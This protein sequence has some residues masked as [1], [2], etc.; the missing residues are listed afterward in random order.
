MLLGGQSRARH[1]P[2]MQASQT[3]GEYGSEVHSFSKVQAG[4]SGPIAHRNQ[5]GWLKG[6]DL[7]KSWRQDRWC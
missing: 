5:S 3:A 4:G 7:Q 1:L 6:A 2:E